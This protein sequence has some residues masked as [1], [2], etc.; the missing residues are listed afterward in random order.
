[1][2]LKFAG[3]LGGVEDKT[4]LLVVALDMEGDDGGTGSML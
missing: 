1:M 3:V 2:L 4:G